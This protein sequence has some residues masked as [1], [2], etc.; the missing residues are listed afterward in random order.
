MNLYSR[1]RFLASAVLVL[2][3][4]AA[5]TTAMAQRRKPHKLRATA[6]VEVTT[7]SAGIVATRVFPVTIL[8]E[9]TFHDAGIYKATPHPMALE[10]GIVYEAQTDGMPVGYA[11]IL[12]STNNKGWTALGK[13]QIADAPK[14]PQ[15]PAPVT[16]GNDRPVIRRD[17]GG[18]PAAPATGGSD[19]RPVLHRGDSSPSPTTSSTPAPSS[20]AQPADRSSN[21]SPTGDSASTPDDADRP[22]LRRRSPQTQDSASTPQPQPTPA[23]GTSDTS[24]SVTATPNPTSGAVVPRT[25][26]PVVLSGTKTFVAVSDNEPTE[27]RSYDFKWKAG[28]EQ[29]MEVK[30]RKLALAQLPRENAQLNTNSLQNVVMRSFD[31]DLS[32]DA[33]IVFSAEIPGSYLSPGGKSAPGKFVSRYV[34]VIA[35]VDFEGIPQKLASSVTDSSRLDV[36]PRLELVDAVDVDGDGLAELL[37][38]EYSFDQKSFII[39]GVGRS[40]VTKVFEGASMPLR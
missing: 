35:R 21:S 36:A 24:R 34:T 2:V 9:G 40:T 11:T 37:F 8:D 19:D 33:V 27:V 22:V 1:S 5:F 31:L 38:R 23:P 17:G 16:A 32:N 39:Y 14:K 3:C 28:E 29:Q 6:V 30:M 18:S 15:V 25:K 7:D 20:P 12:S 26:L 10:N 13:W 4:A